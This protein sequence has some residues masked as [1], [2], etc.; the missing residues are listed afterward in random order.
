[1]SP[2]DG[3]FQCVT[4]LLEEAYISR[5]SI[6]DSY[7]FAD[8][9][10]YVFP[11]AKFQCNGSIESVSG[12]AHFEGLSDGAYYNRTLLLN[13]NL[14]H[15]DQGSYAP[16]GMN[17]NVTLSLDSIASGSNLTDGLF[18]FRNALSHEFSMSVGEP[19][20]HVMAGDILGI[21]LPGPTDYDEG[22][23]QH[24]S[25]PIGLTDDFRSLLTPCEAR[26]L[27]LESNDCPV[28]YSI[29]TPLL[30]FNFVPTS[31]TGKCPICV[32]NLQID[33]CI[34]TN[35]IFTIVYVC[36]FIHVKSV[37]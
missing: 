35:A 21:Y 34:F 4:G 27:R 30:F 29:K 33:A 36:I 14:W 1:M 32:C 20:I 28:V 10:F 23:T 7:S 2:K 6:A 16:T 22:E 13:I 37:R 11:T 8:P 31:V 3:E 17:R 25:I 19:S 18:Y 26:I 24:N 5:L 12:I 9:G 15:R